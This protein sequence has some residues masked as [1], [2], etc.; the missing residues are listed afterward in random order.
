[1]A[2]RVFFT[3][4]ALVLAFSA[5][6]SADAAPEVN[7]FAVLFLF[8]AFVVWFCWHDIQAGYAYL[9]DSGVPRF[10]TSGLMAIRFAPLHLRELA[11]K[12]RR[13]A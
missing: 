2:R 3:V 13:R 9:E 11:G 6:Y 7:L 10:E 4:L 1:M 12:R 8:S 5:F